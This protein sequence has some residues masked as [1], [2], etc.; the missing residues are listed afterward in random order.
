MIYIVSSEKRNISV[1]YQVKKVTHHRYISTMIM[2]HT[3]H[4]NL[5]YETAFITNIAFTYVYL[6]T[7]FN[8]FY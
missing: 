3:M 5:L 8:E 2:N 7:F 6:L 4:N 1:L